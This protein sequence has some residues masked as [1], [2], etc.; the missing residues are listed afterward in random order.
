MRLLLHILCFLRFSSQWWFP[1]SFANNTFCQR[2]DAILKHEAVMQLW[3][4]LDANVFGDI[5]NH[6]DKFNE[7]NAEIVGAEFIAKAYIWRGPGGICCITL[8]PVS[9]W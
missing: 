8:F 4:T 9:G 6:E 1:V 3:P 7:F 5:M 2:Y